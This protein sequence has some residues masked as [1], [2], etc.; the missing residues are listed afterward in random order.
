MERPVQLFGLW[1]LLHC[2]GGDAEHPK[3]HPPVTNL[4][5]SVEHLCTVTWKWNPPEGVSPNCSLQYISHVNNKDKI[6]T[7]ETS[8]SEEVP[9]N[10]KICLQV[11]SQCDT[12]ESENAS[13]LEEKCILPPKGDPESS[14]TNMQCIWHNL[15]YVKCTW[16]PGRNTSPDTNYT[17]Y[18]WYSSLE[19]I[20]QCKNLFREDNYI[21]CSFNLTKQKDD[22]I[23]K[24]NVQ[25]M[26][27]DSEEKSLPFFHIVHLASHVKPDPP[28]I[29]K[30]SFNNST[31]DVQWETP[32]KF[33]KKCLEY[34]VE[35]SNSHT[36]ETQ[37]FPVKD[38]K[39]QNSEFEEENLE[40]INCLNVPAVLPE[41][42]NTVRI[43]AK[44][45]TYCYGDDKIW[46]NWSQAMSIGK[47]A[48]TS[49]Y[50]I[51]L[52]IIPVIVAAAIIVLLLYLKR[53]KIIIFPPIPDPGKIFKEMF[54]D[55]NDDTLH[56]KKYDIYE[57]QMKEETDEVV[58]IENLKRASQ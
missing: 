31:L 29:K 3:S 58:L 4:R 42:L 34:E 21:G 18:Y 41:S 1:A 14:V 8:R 56:W 37:R 32:P 38:A 28:R 46:S 43:R 35:V 26:V 50:I 45:N 2:L 13:I 25:I 57:K 6:I 51:M 54:G 17:F 44:A 52:L 20:L 9:L 53:L 19:E 30:L 22:N 24:Y 16:L 47:K 40:D 11:G 36:K 12:N 5:V 39:C 7:S 48:K 33:V 27:N 55:Q 10:E 49:L 15:N 23:Y